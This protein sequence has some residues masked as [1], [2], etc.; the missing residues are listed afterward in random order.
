MV[1]LN[2]IV[3]FASMLASGSVV[4]DPANSSPQYR[5]EFEDDQ[6]RVLR[7]S[8]RPGEQTAVEDHPDAVL[9]YLTADLD[10]RVPD[11]V[12]TWRPMGTYGLQN[13]ARTSFEALLVE[14]IAPASGTPA[15]IEPEAMPVTYSFASAS[16]EYPFY[17]PDA[18]RASAL[19]ENAR[20]AVSWHRL[21]PLVQ[22]ESDHFHLRDTVLVYLRGG[23]M[24]G[25][26]GQL[27]VHRARRGEFHVMPPNVL[28]ALGNVGNDP[29]EFVMIAPK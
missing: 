4:R 11:E 13:R 16:S 7:V 5:V 10:G 8:L 14:L 19:V 26:T 29:I 24:N 23:E 9:I 21:V 3:I 22:T 15:S 2:L 12:A 27:G 6:V 20:V 25:S 18:H 17:E 28:H 1:A